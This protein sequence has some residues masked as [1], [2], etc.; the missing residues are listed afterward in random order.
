MI[1][2]FTVEEIN[3]I[4]IFDT[5][6]RKRLISELVG[7]I[8]GFDD[9]DLREI[10]ENALRNVSRLTDT[11]FAALEFCPEYGDEEDYD[12]YEEVTT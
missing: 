10:A 6:S 3:L 11:E 5:T 9:A 7:A 4:G 1:E 12:D 8:G 2:Q